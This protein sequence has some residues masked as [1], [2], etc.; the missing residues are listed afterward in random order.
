MTPEQK[1]DLVEQFL[2]YEVKR[3]R[4]RLQEILC[5]MREDIDRALRELEKGED[6][7]RPSGLANNLTD[8]FHRIGELA[9]LRQFASLMKPE[10]EPKPAAPHTYRIRLT[11]VAA[12]GCKQ[13]LEEYE[14]SDKDKV[15]VAKVE[16]DVLLCLDF[17]FDQVYR[18]LRSFANSPRGS[19]GTRRGAKAAALRLF[20]AH[21]ERQPPITPEML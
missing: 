4:G 10:P 18:V 12:L 5:S 13:A 3:A 8:A 21:Q 16:A 7:T 14:A 9:Q 11:P 20:N 17:E 19:A 1:R 6:P 15:L 2:G